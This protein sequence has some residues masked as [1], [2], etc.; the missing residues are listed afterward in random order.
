MGP[1]SWAWGSRLTGCFECALLFGHSRGMGLGGVGFGL[2]GAS[3]PP[4]S[5]P[6]AEKKTM[7]STQQTLRW[8]R[9][10]HVRVA[11]HLLLVRT[12]CLCHA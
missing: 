4:R 6:A 5:W 11:H 1:E 9:V 12:D 3:S 10:L 7:G 2:G 8:R